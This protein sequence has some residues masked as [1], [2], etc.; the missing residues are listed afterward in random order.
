MVGSADGTF[1]TNSAQ[2]MTNIVDYSL[3]DQS[4][5]SIRSRGRF[6]RT[7]PPLERAEQATIEW[8]NYGL[9]GLGIVLLWL[10]QRRRLKGIRSDYG[11]WLT[12]ASA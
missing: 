2:F 4:L 7:L 11:R 1:Y 8:L 12:E 3:E 6:N 5:L 9:A 10:W